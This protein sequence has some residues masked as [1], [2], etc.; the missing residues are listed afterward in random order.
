MLI[1]RKVGDARDSNVH[2]ME[3]LAVNPGRNFARALSN[4]S[5]SP[6]VPSIPF[7]QASVSRVQ[8]AVGH[9]HDCLAVVVHDPDVSGGDR[10][11]SPQLQAVDTAG[12]DVWIEVPQ[13]ESGT[14]AAFKA[15][16]NH[17]ACRRHCAPTPNF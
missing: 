13:A 6:V 4:R 3:V 5:S 10:H 11:V 14:K 17:G 7:L 1:T 9:V 2:V 8:H 16:S 12:S 15:P